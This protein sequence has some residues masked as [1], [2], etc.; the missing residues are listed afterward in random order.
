MDSL[1]LQLAEW[2]LRLIVRKLGV[3]M[4][5]TKIGLGRGQRL[6]VLDTLLGIHADFIVP[7]HIVVQ[8]IVVV[9]A[10]AMARGKWRGDGSG[11]M[12]H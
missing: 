8:K 4:H 10:L 1:I 9:A 5:A 6:C 2:R 7:I 11:F 3:D 12:R